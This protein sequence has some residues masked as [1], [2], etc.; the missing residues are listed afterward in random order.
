MEVLVRTART[1]KVTEQRLSP[2]EQ[3]QLAELALDPRYQALVNVMERACIEIDTGHL[4][5]PPGNPEEVLGGHCV[6]K[7]AWSFFVYV[8]RQVQNAYNARAGES[9]E[10]QTP[11][12]IDDWL[13]GVG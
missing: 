13:Q 3:G 8:Q 10:N 2:E 5:T 9:D 4:N 7:A 6:A 12:E 1:L 11:V